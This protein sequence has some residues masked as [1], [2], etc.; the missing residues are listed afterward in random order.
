MLHD[1]EYG[2]DRRPRFFQARLENGV[3]R[4]PAWEE[5]VTA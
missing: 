5:A 4:V 2:A 1:L 3:M